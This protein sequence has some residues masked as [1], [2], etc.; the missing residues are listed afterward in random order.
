MISEFSFKNGI[1]FPG[2]YMTRLEWLLGFIMFYTKPDGT[3]PQI[4]DN[5]Y[6][7]LHI[8]SDY[9]NWNRL[10][11]R[12]LLSVGAVLFERGDFKAA[13]GDF[14][15]ESFWLVGAEGLNS[16]KDI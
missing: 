15:E 10:D 8:L 16:Y 13:A 7:R 11:H 3:A 1:T 12:Y 6:G 9:G 5:D 14:L 2:W 4:G